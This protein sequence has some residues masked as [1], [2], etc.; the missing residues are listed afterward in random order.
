MNTAIL[1]LLITIMI[2]QISEVNMKKHRGKWK[3]EKEDGFISD[4]ERARL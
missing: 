1:L 3:L 2:V 4:I